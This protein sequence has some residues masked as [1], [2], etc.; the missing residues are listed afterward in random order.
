MMAFKTAPVLLPYKTINTGYLCLLGCRGLDPIGLH[1]KQLRYE[2]YAP[3]IVLPEDIPK[4]LKTRI[5]H[6][7]MQTGLPSVS[8]SVWRVNRSADPDPGDNT[9]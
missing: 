1:R 7:E 9:R 6:N 2:Y 4:I 8:V 3:A 5:R